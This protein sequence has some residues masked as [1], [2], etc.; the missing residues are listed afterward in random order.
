MQHFVRSDMSV[1]RFVQFFQLHFEVS[2][3]IGDNI[4]RFLTIEVLELLLAHLDVID[5]LPA[6]GE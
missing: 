6:T 5:Q 3:H 2:N 4:V 1:D